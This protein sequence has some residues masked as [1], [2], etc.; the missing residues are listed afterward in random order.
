MVYPKALFLELNSSMGDPEFGGVK[1]WLDKVVRDHRNPDSPNY[2]EALA[3]TTIGWNNPL[4]FARPQLDTI[5]DYLSQFD[6]L[7]VGSTDAKQVTRL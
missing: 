7:I 1:N 5:K 6:Y 3:V 2:I 4:T